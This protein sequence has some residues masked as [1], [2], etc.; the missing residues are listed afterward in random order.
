MISKYAF[1]SCLDAVYMC[2][3]TSNFIRKKKQVSIILS[4]QADLDI[5]GTSNRFE[6]LD[7]VEETVDLREVSP[8]WG[9]WSVT[10]DYC[11]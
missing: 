8:F 7:I 2:T 11:K 4:L 1:F 6:T 5:N 10:A 9:F 3:L